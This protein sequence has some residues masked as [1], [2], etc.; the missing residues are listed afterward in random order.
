[1]KPAPGRPVRWLQGGTGVLWSGQRQAGSGTR[2]RHF[3]NARY[4]GCVR[5]SHVH[6]PGY[7]GYARASHLQIPGC[8]DY[9]GMPVSRYTGT[10]STTTKY[11]GKQGVS[12]TQGYQ[13]LRV[14]KKLALV[15]YVRPARV[16]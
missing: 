5:V 4:L 10:L 7:L 2:V 12:G 11:S 6:V 3:Q 9:A 1:M 16:L 13:T 8:V 14:Q 15:L